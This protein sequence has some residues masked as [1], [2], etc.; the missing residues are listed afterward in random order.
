MVQ[1]LATSSVLCPY[2]R[3]AHGES[4]AAVHTLTVCNDGSLVQFYEMLHDSESK[5]QTTRSTRL[6]CLL[7]ET[8]EHVGEQLR[9][10]SR[11]GVSND[12]S[13]HR[14]TALKRHFNAP[15]PR[16]EFDAIRYKVGDDL[17][18]PQR[19]A[20]HTADI[21]IDPHREDDAFVI[22]RSL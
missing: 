4:G 20:F 7:P 10:D 18:K 13:N 17:M 2:R 14:A 16:C 12:E 6:H 21:R 9:R 1:G 15:A 8:L 11:A 5:T 22:G 3:Q 19:I